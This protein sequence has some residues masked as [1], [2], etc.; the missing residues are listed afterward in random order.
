MKI[1]V[2]RIE[3]DIAVVELENG[4]KANIPVALLG[5]ATEGDAI[6]LSVEKKAVDTHSIFEKLRNK[7]KD[8]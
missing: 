4:S 3:E 1:I 6:V 7:S 2:D 5:D 8:T